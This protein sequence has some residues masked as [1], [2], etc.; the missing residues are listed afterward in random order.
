MTSHVALLLFGW[1]LLN[2]AGVPIPVA[3]SLLA[4]GALAA[5]T[6]TGLLMPV[7]VTL[8][9]ALVADLI[10][11]GLG[12]WRGPQ[13]RALP[14]RLSRRSAARVDNAERRLVAHQFSFLLSSR[15][16]PEMNPITAGMAGATGTMLGCYILIA[17][18]SALAWAAAWTGAGYALGN[19]TGDLPTPFGVVTTL[20]LLA[21]AD[22]DG[23]QQRGH[24]DQWKVTPGTRVP[25]A[26][27]HS[28]GAPPG[29]IVEGMRQIPSSV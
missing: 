5:R 8:A 7:V 18:T 16:L 11:Y 6:G 26:A 2:Q 13:A 27:T 22:Q 1:V 15:F 28:Q 29:S 9:G 12:R 14:G 21:G 10:W 3:P 20:G 19:V 17:I 4:A 24:G 25:A 23:D